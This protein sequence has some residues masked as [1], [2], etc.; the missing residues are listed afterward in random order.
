MNKD[1]LYILIKLLQK[2]YGIKDS[3]ELIKPIDQEWLMHYERGEQIWEF[4]NFELSK[5]GKRLF[6]FNIQIFTLDQALQHSL[7]YE[8]LKERFVNKWNKQYSILAFC[9]SALWDCFLFLPVMFIR[10]LKR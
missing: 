6:H 1:E 4:M 8:K 7:E 2:G 10:C 3:I 5:M 9:F